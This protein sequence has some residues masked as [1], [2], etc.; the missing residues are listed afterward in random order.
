[1]CRKMQ[2]E[3]TAR[4]QNLRKQ[5]TKEERRL[6]YEFLKDHS[7]QFRR[8]VVFAPYIVDFY[9]YRAR[10]V[11]EID[12]SGHYEPAQMQ[13]D[14]QRTDYLQSRYGVYVLR[15]TNLEIQKQFRAVCEQI[16]ICISQRL[17]LGEA[18]SEA[19]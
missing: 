15:F 4:A 18:V 12:G 11:I 1:M 14:K 8:Q 2:N 10:L 19:D 7:V 5:M 13:Y 9:A 6:W 16:N 3:L 17:P